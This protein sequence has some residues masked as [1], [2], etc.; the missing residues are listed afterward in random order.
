MRYNFSTSDLAK[1]RKLNNAK[2][3]WRQGDSGTLLYIA[4]D[5]RQV[6]PF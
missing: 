6:Q 1:I 2:F 4:F 3:Q 5:G